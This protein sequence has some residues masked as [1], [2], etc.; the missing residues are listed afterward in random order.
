MKR[1]I[2]L[3]LAVLPFLLFSC[4]QDKLDAYRVAGTLTPTFDQPGIELETVS[5]YLG[6]YVESLSFDEITIDTDDIELV[7]SAVLTE[8]GY[9]EFTDLEKG[10]YSLVLDPQYIFSYDTIQIFKLDE[11]TEHS[12]NKTIEYAAENN[13]LIY[14]PIVT[15]VV[16]NW[17]FICNNSLDSPLKLDS[18][19]IWDSD[20]M[21]E[22]ICLGNS[23][24]E[25]DYSIAFLKSSPSI[26]IEF[27]FFNTDTQTSINTPI[28]TK[29]NAHWQ[30]PVSIGS[31]KIK[32][33]YKW[34]KRKY[35]F[36]FKN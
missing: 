34:S 20:V 6:K 16:L 35:G 17:D 2:N 27:V 1:K 7:D 15:G 3:I 8:D 25:N 33:R 29:S 11:E 21:R 26:G 31:L 9:F 24:G 10:N 14:P 5:I 30:T 28:F 36:F 4:E 18:C 12:I 19:Y 32:Y 13:F 23:K 22:R